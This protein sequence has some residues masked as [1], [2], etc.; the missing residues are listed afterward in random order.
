M[1]C[2]PDMSRRRVP[3]PSD[4]LDVRGSSLRC[5]RVR[6][7]VQRARGGYWQE[8]S[9]LRWG[10]RS[11]SLGPLDGALTVHRPPRCSQVIPRGKS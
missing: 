4:S 8:P 1:N 9:W 3:A 6:R 7:E 11:S 10:Q 2:V 5:R